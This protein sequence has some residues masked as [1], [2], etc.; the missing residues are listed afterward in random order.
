[1]IRNLRCSYSISDGFEAMT[2]LEVDIVSARG[3]VSCNGGIRH[4]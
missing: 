1:M 2:V 3:V 4:G